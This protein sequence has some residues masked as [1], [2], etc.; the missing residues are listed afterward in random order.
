MKYVIVLGSGVIV[1]I[2]GLLGAV[3]LSEERR[4]YRW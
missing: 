2:A 3:W 4:L 1:G